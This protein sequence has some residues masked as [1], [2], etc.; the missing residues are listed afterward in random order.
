MQQ[1][2][3]KFLFDFCFDAVTYIL[4]SLLCVVSIVELRVKSKRNGELVQIY[5]LPQLQRQINVA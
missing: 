5:A 1:P 4:Q 2:L 3:I